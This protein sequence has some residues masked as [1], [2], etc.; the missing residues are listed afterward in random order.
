MIDG[1]LSALR[2]VY[3]PELDES[4]VDLGF[5][6]HLDVRGDTVDIKLRL[7][8]FWCAP[9]FAYL[10]AFD[11]RQAVQQVP[12]IRE[13][14]VSVK[15]HMYSDEISSGVSC[16]QSFSA[17]F[18]EQAEDDNLDALRGVFNRKAFGMRQEQLVRFLQEVGMSAAEIVS[19]QP[20]A[21]LPRGA[22]PLLEQYLSRRARLAIDGNLLVTDTEGHAIA[23][24]ELDV[25][26][27]EQ[28][29]QRISMTFNALMCKGLL[30]TRYELEPARK[31]RVR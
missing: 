8:T 2:R 4:L 12:G 7:P 18:G 25:H 11:A 3:D 14:R 5:I 24:D 13:V 21:E 26:L 6:E 1:V 10:M 27:R 23:A 28:R 19:L 17:T 15:D 20:S 22:T 30:E 9:N 29:R 31:E 16:G